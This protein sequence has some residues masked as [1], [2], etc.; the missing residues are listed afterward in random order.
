MK[1][2]LNKWLGACCDATLH[3]TFIKKRVKEKNESFLLQKFADKNK[4]PSIKSQN[5]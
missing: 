5:S 2:A 3:F 1:G 4:K